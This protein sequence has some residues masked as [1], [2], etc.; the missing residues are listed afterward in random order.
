MKL[1]TSLIAALLI[2]P[3]AFAQ[4]KDWLIDNIGFAANVIEDKGTITLTN[5]LL[6]RSFVLTPN[7]ACVDYRNLG[8]G[9]QLLR[10][11]KP[12]ARITV[13]GKTYDVGSASRRIYS[14]PGGGR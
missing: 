1:L 11:I 10:A 14:P 2:T 9:E 4:Q 7:V 8:N 5:G 3:V 12:E 6:S 13:N